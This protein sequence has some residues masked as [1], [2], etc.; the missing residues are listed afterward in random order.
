MSNI[1]NQLK[2]QDFNRNVD[3][4]LFSAWKK[5][6]EEHKQ[7]G[8]INM[9]LYLVGLALLMVLQGI[10]GLALFFGLAI[11]G[12]ALALPKN[13]K[14]KEL[15]RQLG[16][17]D[18]E[19]KEAIALRRK[20][21]DS[22]PEPDAPH[23]SYDSLDGGYQQP[24]EAP[25]VRKDL[26]NDNIEHDRAMVA[27]PPQYNG[28]QWFLKAL[29]H[30]ADFSGRARRTEY[31][32]FVLFNIIFSVVWILL[33]SLTL[34]IVKDGF[35]DFESFFLSALDGSSFQIMI[36]LPVLALMVRR[37]H[38]VGKSGWMIL[39]LLIPVVGVFWL[40]VLMLTEGQ[41]GANQYGLDPKTSETPF[42][43]PAKVKSA[44][45]VLFIAASVG[46]ILSTTNIINSLVS[47]YGHFNYWMAIEFV[48]SALLLTASIY[49]L[50][51]KQI[52]GMQHGGKSMA[53]LLAATSISLLFSIWGMFSLIRLEGTWQT[54]TNFYI[55]MNLSIS[56]FVAAI[57][58]PP[59]DKILVRYAAIAVIVCSGLVV[60][61]GA[62]NEVERSLFGIDGVIHQMNVLYILTP[63]AYIV[64]AGAYLSMNG[65]DEALCP[66]IADNATKRMLPKEPV[67]KVDLRKEEKPYHDEKKPYVFVQHKVGSKYHS[68]GEE[69][70]ITGDYAE[71]GRNVDCQIRY[72]EQFETVSRRHAAIIR[73]SNQWKLIALS[74]T[75]PTFVNGKA[76]HKE[77]YLQHGD[78]IQ[79]SINGPKLVFKTP[80]S[81]QDP[82]T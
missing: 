78:E 21:K 77:W 71:I 58:F 14:R 15:Q 5:S 30:Y 39:T 43:E 36:L 74:Q 82:L 4:A 66:E 28:L 79:C 13:N 38:D 50:K 62:Y 73:E 55:Y 40:L 16:I 45:I 75:N 6:V 2:P 26:R 20:R 7:A 47:F 80:A 29:V 24:A 33:T 41:Q 10:V 48:T 56:L 31:W 17:S 11:A 35:Y 22:D 18:V 63:I 37:L 65:S 25:H 23:V 54:L 8:I 68:P 51:E 19:L 42:D 49:L 57:L 34:A 12:I 76:V 44:G 27:A 52:C 32:Y 64:L 3:P 9:V 61:Q 59:Q 46:L 69:Q 60:F 1:I 53:I 70:K 67:F 81:H 72:D